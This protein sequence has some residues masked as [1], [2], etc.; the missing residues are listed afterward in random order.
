MDWLVKR[1]YASL[2]K[3]SEFI[4]SLTSKR[5]SPGFE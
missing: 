1:I 3:A 5:V 2:G 4:G